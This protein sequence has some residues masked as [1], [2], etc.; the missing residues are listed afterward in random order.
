MSHF[1]EHPKELV[2]TTC[3]DPVRNI[4]SSL[5]PKKTVCDTFKVRNLSD[6]AKLFGVAVLINWLAGGARVNYK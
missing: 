1:L 4:E 3:F 2:W 5:V 6:A